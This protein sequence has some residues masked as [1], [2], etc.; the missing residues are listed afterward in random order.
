MGE[1]CERQR[2]YVLH[3][4]AY[5][6]TSVLLELF[7]REHGRVGAVARGVRAAKPRFARGTLRAF[8]PLECGWLLQG[9]L[10]Q[11]TAVEAAGPPLHLVG[12]RLQAAL[13]LN[14]LLMRLLARQDPHAVLFDAYA[15]LLPAL[16]ESQDA[17]AFRLRRF[18]MQVLAELGYGID[19]SVDAASGESITPARR[20]RVI[21]EHGVIAAAVA[22][23]D[24]ISGRALLA[25][26]DDRLPDAVVLREQ[27]RMMR[28]LLLH[29]LGGRG[30]NAWRVL[31][32]PAPPA[33]PA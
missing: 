19:F 1:R 30:L 18:E 25:L 13:Y 24:G 4:R 10:V 28:A 22:D 8:Q 20:Y 21:P 14:E 33:G 27:R 17:L 16:P 5:R 9:E 3:E 29:H 23:E 32:A 7:S 31:K 26:L 6:E 12:L 11:L 2:A 15:A